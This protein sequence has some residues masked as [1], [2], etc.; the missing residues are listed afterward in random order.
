MKLLKEI[1]QETA[2][3]L[4][5]MAGG[6]LLFLLVM[7]ASLAIFAGVMMATGS[8]LRYISVEGGTLHTLSAGESYEFE[9]D[10]V[11]VAW[12]TKAQAER[13]GKKRTVEWQSTDE[14]VLV[15]DQNGVVTALAPGEAEVKMSADG[16]RS[17]TV[18][19]FIVKE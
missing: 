10:Y 6:I 2:E 9:L 13:E 17:A 11:P 8:K 4:F 16:F 18:I 14:S 3:K 12:G 7:A 5:G 1:L 15:V 19:K